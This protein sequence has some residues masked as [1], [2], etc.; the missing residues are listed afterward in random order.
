MRFSKSLYRSGIKSGKSGC[1][2][3]VAILLLVLPMAVLANPASIWEH[4]YNPA[5]LST[6]SRAVLD[7]GVSVSPGF[8]NSSFSIGQIF[9][10]TIRINLDEVYEGLSDAGMGIGL[11]LGAEAHTTLHLLGLGLGAYTDLSTLGQMWIPKTFFEVAANGFQSGQTYTGEGGLMARSFLEYG[12]YGSLRLIQN[13]LRV[14]VKLAKFLPLAYTSEANTQFTVVTNGD[15]SAEATADISARLYSAFDLEN[16]DTID[17]S[18]LLSEPGSGL[19]FD[20]GL[21]Y[22][23]S[24]RKPQLGVALTNVTLKPAI[25]K[26]G[27]DYNLQATATVDSDPLQPFVDETDES[28]TVD[29]PISNFESLALIDEEI[30]MPITLSAFYRYTGLRLIDIIPNAAVVLDDPLRVN[31]GV[32]VEGAIFPFSMLSLGMAYQDLAWRTSAGI[33]VNLH[34]MEL[35]VNLSSTSPEFA[36]LLKTNGVAVDVKLAFGF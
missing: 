5:L 25:P 6:S 24:R 34:L 12:A 32:L 13:R 19:K 36:T 16:L 2:A 9:Q 29:D 21:V 11:N 31:A 17:P 23:G 15:G 30:R 26:F 10:E 22:G 1:L 27:W 18:T 7:A 8:Q 28:F 3:L 35:G 33:K 20:I 14:G 4:R